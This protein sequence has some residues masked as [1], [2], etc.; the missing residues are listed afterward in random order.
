MTH[1]EGQGAAILYDRSNLY[2]L[3]G[4]IILSCE[5]DKEYWTKVKDIDNY[6]TMED[7]EEIHRLACRSKHEAYICPSS[8]LTVFTEYGHLKRGRCCGC[9]CRHC[10]YRPSKNKG[11]KE[12]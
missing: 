10:P 6:P 5:C 7:I 2:I 11:K 1:D 8:G 3:S 12:L 4:L 9:G